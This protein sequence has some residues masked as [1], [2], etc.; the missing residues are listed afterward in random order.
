[1]LGDTELEIFCESLKSCGLLEKI[2]VKYGQDKSI[3]VHGRQRITYWLRY[4]TQ[5]LAEKMKKKDVKAEEKDQ[6]M[7]KK[8]EGQ[9]TQ[10]KKEKKVTE[11]SQ[12]GLVP[13]AG[14]DL[15]FPVK[16]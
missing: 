10:E 9:K 14:F 15:L 11:E 2:I 8:E 1:M 5:N 3:V 13:V 16:T 7:E 6:E 12:E 4:K